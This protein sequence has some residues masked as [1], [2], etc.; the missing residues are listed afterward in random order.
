MYR[1]EGNQVLSSK[2]LLERWVVGKA[3]HT[4]EHGELKNKHEDEVVCNGD[5]VK[6]SKYLLNTQKNE[7]KEEEWKPKNTGKK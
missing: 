1:K 5:E 7:V 6:I 4:K 2:K 3:G